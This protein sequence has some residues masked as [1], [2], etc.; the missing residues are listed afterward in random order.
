MFIRL[1]RYI[2]TRLALVIFSQGHQVVFVSS[3]GIKNQLQLLLTSCVLR[4]ISRSVT[5][6]RIEGHVEDRLTR[7]SRRI[8]FDRVRRVELVRTHINL[9]VLHTFGK[10]H[11]VIRQLRRL[12]TLIDEGVSDLAV[13][14]AFMYQRRKEFSGEF[15]STMVDA[16]YTVAQTEVVERSGTTFN[17]VAVLIKV[18]RKRRIGC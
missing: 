12:Y 7:M 17:I 11:I 1:I 16:T 10:C 4:R 8:R 15:L 9:A 14:L 13:C 2:R 5:S 3:R 18:R 6:V